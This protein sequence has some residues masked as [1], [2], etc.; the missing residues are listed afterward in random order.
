MKR[1]W[2]VAM[3]AMS[4]SLVNLFS[5]VAQASDT[6][7]GVPI[8][9]VIKSSEMKRSG[10]DFD[11][12]QTLEMTEIKLLDMAEKELG[13]TFS[14]KFT[15]EYFNFLSDLSETNKYCLSANDSENIEFSE[16]A[17]IYL[18]RIF[19]NSSN[20]DRNF[21]LSKTF[22]DIKEENIS[23]L[24]AAE[25]KGNIE[26]KSL[27]KSAVFSPTKATAYA[28]KYA[29]T[30]NSSYQTFSSDCTNFASQ[31]AFA[32][33]KKK[34]WTAN[35]SGQAW[36]WDKTNVY[37]QPWTVAMAF[38]NYWTA[39]GAIALSY[40]SKASAQAAMKPGAFVAYWKKNTYQVTHIAYCNAKSNGKAYV[41]QHTTNFW[42][43]AFDS[44]D[45][46]AYSS[47]ILLYI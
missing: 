46:S 37:S 33:G 12:S 30:P 7:E 3:V 19:P 8:S 11:L 13:I 5:E 36:Y 20:E 31:I 26:K 45:T 22:S 15:E 1:I 17:G 2:K 47:F 43:Q 35:G 39:D 29:I 4:F 32:G 14:N 6:M 21:L 25:L 27:V 42:N 23:F 34:V 44:R 9:E 10:A 24:L 18:S 41:T 16:F 28:K 40:T 38:T